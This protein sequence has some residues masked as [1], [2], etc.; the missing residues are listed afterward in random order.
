MLNGVVPDAYPEP[1][2]RCEKLWRVIFLSDT[3]AGQIFDII[4]LW[5]ILLSV[6]T[7]MLESVESLRAQYSQWF[8]AVEC[9]FTI[10]F[11]IEYILRLWVIRQRMKC[12]EFL[13]HP[14]SCSPDLPSSLCPPES[15]LPGW[16]G[17]SATPAGGGDATNA[18][19]PIMIRAPVSATSAV[20]IWRI[21]SPFLQFFAA[22]IHQTPQGPY[23]TLPPFRFK[24]PPSGMPL[25]KKLSHPQN[26]VT[27]HQAQVRMCLRSNFTRRSDAP[28]RSR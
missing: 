21:E 10:A 14:S 13:W 12:P 6:L 16:G 22:K 5:M 23:C 20:R 3:R 4:L 18:A 24:V 17:N 15:L 7:I 19:G 8:I 25:L 2:A 11:T 9:F 26:H 27:D 28:S 1:H